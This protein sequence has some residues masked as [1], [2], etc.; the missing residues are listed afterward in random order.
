MLGVLPLN[1]RVIL[2]TLV[3]FEPTTTRSKGE[4][5]LSIA[6]KIVAETEGLEPKTVTSP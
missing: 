3:G 5:T 1:Y 2:L 6:A 4:V